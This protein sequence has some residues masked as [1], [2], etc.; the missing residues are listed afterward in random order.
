ML[1]YFFLPISTFVILCTVYVYI[2]F[3]LP[4]RLYKVENDAIAFGTDGV[5][6]LTHAFRV[7]SRDILRDIK[8]ISENK[9]IKIQL[10]AKQAERVHRR[11]SELIE[12]LSNGQDAIIDM[13]GGRTE[14][15]EPQGWRQ[16]VAILR[17]KEYNDELL[18]YCSF[19]SGL[20]KQRIRLK[21]P[22]T[23]SP[24]LITYYSLSSLQAEI[25]YIEL[26]ALNHILYQVSADNIDFH[27]YKPLIAVDKNS[28]KH[29]TVYQA[30]LSLI[31]TNPELDIQLTCNEG[32][33]TIE[34]GVAKIRSI[35]K[36]DKFDTQGY[37]EKQLK[38]KMTLHYAGKDTTFSFMKSYTVEKK[39]RFK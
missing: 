11:T 9:N 18:D 29:R 28:V 13:T 8:Y 31:K 24:L 4:P 36:A 14:T 39:N 5:M 10:L 30:Y 7:E 19:V 37:A 34:N 23:F 12:K 3:V 6:E 20:I 27:Y 1:K 25:S 35:A 15:G 2:T 17:T 21:T 26:I 22:D 38:G 16:P 32:E 33:V